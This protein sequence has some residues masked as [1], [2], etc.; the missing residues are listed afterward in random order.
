[1]KSFENFK[2]K[3]QKKGC[4]ITNIEEIRANSNRRKTV[5]SKWAGPGEGPKEVRRS[6]AENQFQVGKTCGWALMGKE[7]SVHS[8]G[9][10][11]HN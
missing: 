1:M 7:E 4:W 8:P 2:L 3:W 11:Y 5:G 6:E 10:S 9:F